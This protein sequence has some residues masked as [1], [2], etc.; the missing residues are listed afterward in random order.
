MARCLCSR[1]CSVICSKS[2]RH[3]LGRSPRGHPQQIRWRC[4]QRHDPKSIKEEWH[5]SCDW[6]PLFHAEVVSR[7]W[8]ERLQFPAEV[9]HPRGRAA[10]GQGQREGSSWKCCSVSWALNPIPH[11]WAG[12]RVYFKEIQPHVFYFLPELI[13]QPFK[14]RRRDYRSGYPP[15]LFQQGAEAGSDVKV[16]KLN[17]LFLSALLH[18]ACR[19][20]PG[21][22]PVLL[23][24]T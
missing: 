22:Q 10:Q 1:Q 18:L 8:K 16:S 15:R 11:C 5:F 14:S 2:A 20:H 4:I 3:E 7:A 24:S 21:H 12:L 9:Q 6:I 17:Q 13:D 23:T 19:V